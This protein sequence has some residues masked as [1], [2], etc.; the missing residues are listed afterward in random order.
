MISLTSF[1]NNQ[2]NQCESALKNFG[3]STQT[4]KRITYTAQLPTLLVTPS[5]DTIIGLFAAIPAAFSKSACRYHNTFIVGANQILSYP[6]VCLITI[7]NPNA[8]LN[9]KNNLK[10]LDVVSALITV[11]GKYLSNSESMFKRHVI[12]RLVFSLAPLSITITAVFKAA[13]GL[14][15]APLAIITLGNY[16]KLNVLAFYGLRFTG[17]IQDITYVAIKIINPYAD[18]SPTY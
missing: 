4:A 3:C 17:M 11:I 1:T 10:S 7:I 12:S 9:G 16:S 2:F 14:I 6:F 15:A 8:S 5:I 18:C 13:V